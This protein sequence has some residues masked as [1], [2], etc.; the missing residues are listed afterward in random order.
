MSRF[1][2]KPL[3]FC[4]RS[5][6]GS[7]LFAI[8]AAAAIIQVGRSVFPI[9]NEYR[10]HF[11]QAA[12][13]QLGVNVAIGEIQATWRGLR[14]SIALDNV[15]LSMDPRQPG[16]SVKR[17]EAQV[18]ILALIRD[19]RSALRKVRFTGVK[20]AL[21]Q[22]SEG[23]WNI[24]GLPPSTG[25]RKGDF[26]ID[27]PLDIFLFGR[28]IQLEDTTLSLQFADGLSIATTIPK[29]ALENDRDFHR[30]AAVFVLEG[31]ESFRFVMEGEGDPRDHQNFAAKGYLKLKKFP[32]EKV[33]SALQGQ[34]EQEPQLDSDI[35]DEVIEQANGDLDLQLWFNGTSKRGMQL[36]GHVQL[37]GFPLEA[38]PGVTL[39]EQISAKLKGTWQ[40]NDGWDLGFNQLSVLWQGHEVPPI[41]LALRGSI[42]KNFRFAFDKVDVQEWI[43]L[44]R[45][46]GLLKGEAQEALD[47]LKP[48]GTLQNGELVLLSKEEGYVRLRA[49]IE[50]GESHA[51]YGAPTL[52]GI[53]GFVDTSVTDGFVMLDTPETFEVDL[54]RVYK[55]PMVFERA[56]GVVRWEVDLDKKWAGLSSNLIELDY[57]G[58]NAVGRLNLSLPFVASPGNEQKMTLVIGI[59]EAPASLHKT[60]LP[61]TV[62]QDLYKW[63]NQA[64][65]GGEVSDFAFVYNGSVMSKPEVNPGLQV[66]GKVQNASIKFAP[67][68]PA[69]TQLSGSL[70][71]D[72]REVI[73]ES[74]KGRLSNLDI[75]GAHLELIDNPEQEGER[76]I[77]VEGYAQGESSDA[78]RL[79]NQSPLKEILGDEVSGWKVSG[80]LNG[81]ANLLIPLSESDK[82]AKH[83]VELSFRNLSVFMPQLDLPFTSVAGGLSYSTSRGVFSSGLQGKLWG[84]SFKSKIRTAEIAKSEHILVDFEG[85]LKAEDARRWTQLP[86]LRFVSGRTELE[87]QL[88]V[89]F[90][91]NRA[92]HVAARSDLE[93]AV[94]DLPAPF[95]KPADYAVPMLLEVELQ[96]G[97]EGRAGEDTYNIALDRGINAQIVTSEEGVLGAAVAIGE[98]LEALEQGAIKISG[99]IESAEFN[100]WDDALDRYLKYSL[101][102]QEQDSEEEPSLPMSVALSVRELYVGETPFDHVSVVAQ[103][104]ADDWKVWIESESLSGELEIFEDSEQPMLAHFKRIVLPEQPEEDPFASQESAFSDI[105]FEEVDPIDFKVD[106]FAIGEQSYGRWS[107]K[108]RPIAGG[109]VAYD[110][111]GDMHGLKLSGRN[112][113]GAELVWLRSENGDQSYLTGM[114]SG[115]NIGETLAGFGVKE[116]LTSSSV[117]LD[118]EAQWAGAPDQF[119][120]EKLF[121]L[122]S[123][124]MERGRFIRGAS[125]AENPLLKLIG[126]LN[127]DTL[128][129]RLRLD[130]SDLNPEGMAYERV[131]GTFKFNRGIVNVVDELRVETPSTN[132]QFAGDINIPDQTVDAQV[133]ATLPVAGNLTMAAALTGGLPAAVGVFV[134]GKIFK[135]Q[136]DKVSSVRY[137]VKGS[138]LEPDVEV[139][140][141]FESK[142]DIVRAEEAQAG[143]EQEVQSTSSGSEQDPPPATDSGSAPNT[144]DKPL[145][146]QEFNEG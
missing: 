23:V 40:L 112:S 54:P 19:W 58:A 137:S 116:A 72:N 86:E 144:E 20:T 81:E 63:M 7:L 78:M 26:A 22:N 52:K 55:K 83:F 8:I 14:P 36:S 131:K 111:S 114:A 121:G 132:I 25:N 42:E 51:W 2:K 41:N 77:K 64:I 115:L 44:L 122:V 119:T 96:P 71:V 87:G 18:S 113:S 95:Y 133:V 106:E 140:K 38:E 105:H 9:L 135:K 128:A 104:Q 48:S 117:K 4:V 94:I 16:L 67:D 97:V 118:I 92:I 73:A 60:F 57:Q 125:V 134:V 89:P 30:L 47:E 99:S 12:S 70:M 32:A 65:K 138:W 68:W 6:W 88:R 45:S 80:P 61:Y 27:D 50:N 82:G 103:S 91:S 66:M 124:N 10:P 33:I 139:E 53:R 102:M 107:F 34:T 100:A 120:L 136:V 129:R 62:P 127:F 5:F 84:E 59:K 3:L 13:D 123:V 108:L 79:V 109:L 142:T 28:R 69:M 85:G 93:G 76:A 101:E 130:F 17:V 39:P 35:G 1:V 31:Q 74:L 146:Q 98:P 15:V 49:H 75:S 143:A 43:N 29:I 46:S 110:L 90:D 37:N 24:Q 145:S 56:K 21:E 141:V 11:E 126:L